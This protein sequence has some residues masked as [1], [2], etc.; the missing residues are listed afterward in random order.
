MRRRR[1][2]ADCFPGSRDTYG[3]ATLHCWPVTLRCLI[4]DDSPQF[5]DHNDGSVC[6]RLMTIELGA[7]V[8]VHDTLAI[9]PLGV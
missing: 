5:H 7:V 3:A 2:G 1:P 4:V 6:G 8:V 9:Y